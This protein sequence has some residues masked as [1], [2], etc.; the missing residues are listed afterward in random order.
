MDKFYATLQICSVS[1]ALGSTDLEAEVCRLR[2]LIFNKKLNTGQLMDASL[3]LQ[4]AFNNLS[5]KQKNHLKKLEKIIQ[6]PIALGLLSMQ[7]TASAKEIDM[8]AKILSLFLDVKI[9]STRTNPRQVVFEGLHNNICVRMHPQYIIK[10][11]KDHPHYS[12]K[13]NSPNNY[14]AIDLAIELLIDNFRLAVLGIE[15]DGHAAHY[16]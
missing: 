7:P 14:W 15:Y 2:A 13:N 8:I 6:P 3:F 4:D 5:G 12:G 1:R 9:Y 10:T 16:I 11:P